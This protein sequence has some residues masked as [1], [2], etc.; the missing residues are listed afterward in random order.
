MLHSKR[1]ILGLYILPVY[2]S[3]VMINNETKAIE[4]LF[5]SWADTAKYLRQL[6]GDDD[7]E[8]QKLNTKYS[9]DEVTGLRRL[10]LMFTLGFTKPLVKL[11]NNL[12]FL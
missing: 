6:T 7:A 5:K 11:H 10:W 8:V 12:L 2:S 9:L 4:N 3:I 1:K